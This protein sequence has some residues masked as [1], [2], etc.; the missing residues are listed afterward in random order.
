MRADWIRLLGT[1]VREGLLLANGTG[2]GMVYCLPWQRQ[3]ATSPF[4]MADIGGPAETGETPELDAKPP[5]LDSKP[6][7]LGVPHQ[8]PATYY[9]W[10][11]IP[12][13]LQAQLQ[14]LAA[15]VAQRRKA[16]A[17][18]LRETVRTLCQERL[19]GL[20]VLAHLLKRNSDDLRKRTL[21]P[22]G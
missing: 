8:K 4:G 21:P 7:E 12:P 17:E 14:A 11:A 1:L 18:I 6:P 22:H 15:P 5:E 16:S 9:D 2:R 13:D 20:R 10:N 3:A 19:L